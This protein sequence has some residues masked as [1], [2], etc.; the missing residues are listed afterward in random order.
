[1]SSMPET[2]RELHWKAQEIASTVSFK[3]WT[4]AQR[5][6]CEKSLRLLDFRI[7]R[8]FIETQTTGFDEL[9]KFAFGARLMFLM[10]EA[11]IQRLQR[12][13][14]DDVLSDDS[15]T[16]AQKTEALKPI[17]AEWVK[18]FSEERWQQ[19]FDEHVAPV[20][21][22]SVE[23]MPELEPEPENEGLDL[24]QALRLDRKAEWETPRT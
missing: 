21:H 23:S 16:E 2:E 8:I 1:M 15:L 12:C 5:L 6:I 19:Y 9:D 18:T 14:E 7:L 22:K 13:K 11:K 20:L 3:N 17:Y 24:I 10:R 4:E